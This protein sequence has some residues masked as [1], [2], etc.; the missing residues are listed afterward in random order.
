MPRLTMPVGEREKM[1]E[2]WQMYAFV[3]GVR[4]GVMEEVAGFKLDATAIFS[5]LLAI[6]LGKEK[7]S[8]PCRE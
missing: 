5:L 8:W 7:V 4:Y 2:D 1:L 6:Q 3:G